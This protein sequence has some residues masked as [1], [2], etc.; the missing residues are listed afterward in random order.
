VALLGAVLFLP[1]LGNHDLWNP[2]E[3]RYAT[4]A[5]EMLERGDLLV[6][7]FNGEVYAHKP[8]LYFW[9][10]QLASLPSGTVDEIAARL[11]S[12]LTAIGTLLLAFGIGRRLFDRRAAW[13]AVAVLATSARILW[14]GRVGQIDMLLTFVVTLAMYCWLR[15]WLE[16]RAGMFRLFFVA[17]GLAVLAKGPAG[18]LPPLL[19]VLVFL[20]LVRDG[21][22]VRR[23]QIGRGLL[24]S[25]AVVAAWL[26]PATLSAGVEYAQELVFKQAIGRYADPW[27]HVR[28]WYYYLAVL[29]GDFF[30]WS[31]LLPTALVVGWRRVRGPA[32]TGWLWALAW[33]GVTLAFFSLSPGKRSIYV[34][35]MY[36]G[37]ALLVASALRE[38]ALRWPRDRRALLWPVG[39]L[40][41]MLLALTAGV[42]LR[43]AELPGLVPLGSAFVWA[44]AGLLALLTVATFA[45]WIALLRGQVGAAVTRMAAGMAAFGLVLSGVALPRVD[46]FKSARGLS[47]ELR[48]RIGAGEVWG[49]QRHADA[50]FIFYTGL[51]AEVLPTDDDVRAFAAR[52]GRVWLIS[53]QR[54]LDELDPPLPMVEVA[55]DRDLTSEHVLLVS[56]PAEAPPAAP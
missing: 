27:H 33:V 31:T 28:P 18:L 32:R 19:S 40:A 4:V 10:I 20:V 5:R 7:Y 52:P 11:P 3:P 55:R 13:I 14:Q 16:R 9:A 26:V 2:D 35:T 51:H 36:P 47:E 15:G 30:P 17:C 39:L 37:L 46:P 12:A 29:P 49:I 22:A 38:L 45:A 25:A 43:F 50:P 53:E 21:E 54:Y 44:L 34:L 8:P 24:I 1:F 42:P 56:A 41:G 6:P 23:M 48:S